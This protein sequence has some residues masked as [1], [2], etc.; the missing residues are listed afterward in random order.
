[1]DKNWVAIVVPL[2]FFL[3]LLAGVAVSLY[4]RAIRER[5]RHET[6]RRMVEK[7]QEIPSSLLIPAHQPVSDLRRGLVLLG[8]GIGLVVMMAGADD[9]DLRSMWGAGLIPTLMGVAHLVT[10]VLERKGISAAVAGNGRTS[11]PV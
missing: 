11:D 1:M 2:G 7:G 5:E 8:A 10:W 3:C 4:F 9:H 6:L